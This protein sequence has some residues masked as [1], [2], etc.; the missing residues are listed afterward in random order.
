MFN[1]V[2]GKAYTGNNAVELA[3]SGFEDMRFMTFNQARANGRKVK[4]GSEGIKLCRIVVRE[5]LNKKT[6]KL[7]KKKAPKYFTVFNIAQTEEV[8]A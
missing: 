2:T 3:N 8:P 1:F 5:E 6:G 4:K 7:E